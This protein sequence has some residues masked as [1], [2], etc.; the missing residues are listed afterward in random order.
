MKQTMNGRLF[1]TV[2][3]PFVYGFLTVETIEI[4][5]SMKPPKCWRQKDK[6]TMRSSKICK[7]QSFF[8]IKCNAALSVNTSLN[9]S[10]FKETNLSYSFN[11]QYKLIRSNDVLFGCFPNSFYPILYLGNRN[12]L[13]L[14]CD[15]NAWFFKARR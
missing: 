7:L 6:A 14:R 13:Y 1:I 15:R 9:S 2:K 11:A 4:I 12:Y 10:N 8:S 3:I 5:M